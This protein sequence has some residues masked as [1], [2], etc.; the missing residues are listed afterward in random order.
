MKGRAPDNPGDQVHTCMDGNSESHL[1]AQ[2]TITLD[3]GINGPNSTIDFLEVLSLI[4][5]S[6]H[7]TDVVRSV[8]ELG[9]FLV[10]D[11]KPRLFT[12]LLSFRKENTNITPN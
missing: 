7:L 5:V 1:L 12:W 4:E 2:A 9:K 8:A 3:E 11:I 6:Y 10:D